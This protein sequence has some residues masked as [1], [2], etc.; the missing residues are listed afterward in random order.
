MNT[1]EEVWALSKSRFLQT[2]ASLWLIGNKALEVALFV[3]VLIWFYR[4][5]WNECNRITWSSIDSHDKAI[6]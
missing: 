5:C 6:Y 2:K 1:D 4:R 3:G